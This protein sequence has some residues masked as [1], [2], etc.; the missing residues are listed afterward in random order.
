MKYT[1]LT[2]LVIVF[3]FLLFRF[4]CGQKH[5]YTT[6]G[7][8]AVACNIIILLLGIIVCIFI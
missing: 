2:I 3:I 5:I 6:N 8:G 7:F 4:I 1:I